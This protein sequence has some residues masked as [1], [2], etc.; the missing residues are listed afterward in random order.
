MKKHSVNISLE[1]FL[2]NVQRDGKSFDLLTTIYH[3]EE[4]IKAANRK[5]LVSLWLIQSPFNIIRDL[6]QVINED[7]PGWASKYLIKTI[8]IDKNSIYISRILRLFC[9]TAFLFASILNVLYLLFYYY[10]IV[11]IVL[12][13]DY[14]IKIDIIVFSI[15]LLISFL[16][17]WFY[18]KV[19]CYHL[20]GTFKRIKKIMCRNCEVTA[21]YLQNSLKNFNDFKEK[22]ELSEQESIISKQLLSLAL[23]LAK[24]EYNNCKDVADSLEDEKIEYKSHNT[25]KRKNSEKAKEKFTN[26][27][28][29]DLEKRIQYYESDLNDKSREIPYQHIVDPSASIMFAT[30]S[31][32]RHLD[33]L[34]K[35]LEQRQGEIENKKM[36]RE[37]LANIS[38]ARKGFAYFLSNLQTEGND[39][40]KKVVLQDF[41]DW[42]KLNNNYNIYTDTSIINEKNFGNSIGKQQNF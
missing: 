23:D 32:I 40:F 38:V 11:G 3:I 9:L 39:A 21:E 30:E 31:I 8:W 35:S 34:R 17:G 26:A 15:I 25:N 20:L 14:L 12:N 4:V 42:T 10:K 18:F 37:R 41:L 36:L 27:K 1:K 33:E 5:T 2:W 28:G 13:I 7:F 19:V 6:E 22:K 24:H 29:R 16:Y